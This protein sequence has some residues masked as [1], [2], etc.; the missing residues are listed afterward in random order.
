[1]KTTR[2]VAVGGATV[3]VAGS[4][5]VGTIVLSP[6]AIA[7]YG[8]VT[9][10]TAVNIRTQPTTSSNVLGVL[11]RGEKLKQVGAA[12]N[13]W[14][15]VTYGARTAWISAMY[16]VGARATP[17][18]PPTKVASKGA[19]W[20]TTALNVRS[21][22]RIADNKVGLLPKGTKVE[23][24]GLIS[25]QFSQIRWKD[26]RAWVATEYLTGTA[27]TPDTSGGIT[28][29]TV[30]QLRATA[31]LAVRDAK[32][33]DTGAADIPNGTVLGTT[34]KKT[35]TLVQVVWKG[36]PVWVTARYTAPLTSSTTPKSNET[37]T[38]IGTQYVTTGLNVRSGP[39]TT[40]GVVTTLMP[41][42][43]VKVTGKVKSGFA[44]ISLN[45]TTRW[46]SAQ[47][48]SAKKPSSSG[49]GGSA[50]GTTGGGTID[51]SGSIGLSGL[52]PNARNIVNVIA[53]RY[54]MTTFYGVRHD[55]LPDHPSGHAV[56]IMIPNYRSS[57]SNAKGWEIARYLR[58]NADSLGVQYVIFDQKIWN[59]SR[60]AE[61]WRWMADRG[62]DT[63]NH[64][65]HVHVTTVGL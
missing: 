41:G 43:P 60:D 42:T 35:A 13:G 57:A 12:R 23:L 48:L 27:Q 38:T 19:S 8:T 22:P 44:A 56:D 17:D 24:T 14:V 52:E 55:S 63:V 50:G 37:V 30:G 18:A 64:R 32:G 49:G 61:G 36:A 59:R 11:Y 7:N 33:R 3:V 58:A 45:G 46:V 4:L 29:T 20:T 54:A 15:P 21:L 40:Y 16:I 2:I 1:M 47:Y 62:G 51:L 5:A 28:T 26:D 34:G 6:Q 39:G 53:S 65:D 25:G 9:A 10:T 31:P